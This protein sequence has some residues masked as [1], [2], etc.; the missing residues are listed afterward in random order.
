MTVAQVAAA[1]ANRSSPFL[2]YRH[3]F[4]G[5]P[6]AFSPGSLLQ[7]RPP[8]LPREAFREFRRRALELAGVTETRPHSPSVQKP[9]SATQPAPPESSTT[10]GSAGVFQPE[11]LDLPPSSSSSSFH[12][13]VTRPLMGIIARDKTRRLCHL[14]DLVR[15]A[16]SV[17]FEV[18]VLRFELWDVWQQIREAHRLDV[19]A[20]S[21]GAGMSNLVWLPRGAQVLEIFPARPSALLLPGRTL[22]PA[23]DYGRWAL[24][25]NVSHVVALQCPLQ[26][27]Q[28]QVGEQVGEKVGEQ[29]GEQV[30]EQVEATEA[31]EEFEAAVISTGTFREKEQSDRF[32]R[33][34][35]RSRSSSRSRKAGGPTGLYIDLGLY[36]APFA[37][38]TDSAAGD[39]D[40]MQVADSVSIY[41][42]ALSLAPPGNLPPAT[43][44]FRRLDLLVGPRS[45]QTLAL[46]AIRRLERTQPEVT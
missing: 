35:G 17:G 10:L 4:L 46:Q 41:T 29:V 7:R 2:C 42:S 3:A 12:P 15:A 30:R 28:C 27:E 22:N 5:L 38:D 21:H 44:G 11:P 8:L 18:Q 40:E 23:S 19:L 45:F 24:V 43:P 1:A 37:S 31:E 16:E 6:P 26:D 32:R 9:Q 14:P 20:G 39:M 36:A 13:P 25:C 34:G 33:L